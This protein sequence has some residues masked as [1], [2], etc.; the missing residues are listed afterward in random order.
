MPGD[1][2]TA[3]SVFDFFTQFTLK[4]NKGNYGAWY[5]FGNGIGLVGDTT[6]GHP[7]KKGR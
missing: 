4:D 1:L 3:S 6:D 7:W 5:G 2:T